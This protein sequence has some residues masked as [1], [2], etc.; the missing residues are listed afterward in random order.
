MLDFLR[1]KSVGENVEVSMSRVKTLL[2]EN[3]EAVMEFR[4]LLNDSPY[5]RDIC[6]ILLPQFVEMYL[7]DIEDRYNIDDLVM[8]LPVCCLPN[9]LHEFALDSW[10]S[11]WAKSCEC[12]GPGSDCRLSQARSLVG[13]V[14]IEVLKTTVTGPL[15]RNKENYVLSISGQLLSK[16][17]LPESDRPV[18][19]ISARWIECVV[20]ICDIMNSLTE[21]E[22]SETNIQA[23]SEVS[24]RLL[25]DLA[26]CQLLRPRGIN[27]SVTL[28]YIVNHSQLLSTV[29]NKLLNLDGE[30][31]GS[32]RSANFELENYHIAIFVLL[33][34][35]RPEVRPKL[36]PMVWSDSRRK[37][38]L[39]WSSLALLRSPF[40][41]F[42]VELSLSL[43]TQGLVKSDM[44]AIWLEELL[45][46]AN[47][48]GDERL[49][50]LF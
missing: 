35:M 23:N 27:D 32:D 47:S 26:I 5:C 39:M 49:L 44:S 29:E 17:L 3:P 19:T 8:F 14:I 25:A 15:Y 43:L 40:P 21:S 24:L 30:K 18:H 46:V 45:T 48:V 42:G 34:T 7:Q 36:M 22:V 4:G 6:P 33:A 16:F 2:Y 11:L 13:H 28:K 12:P 50:S 9:E 41:T 20:S 1:D 31:T 37:C 10:I 38:V